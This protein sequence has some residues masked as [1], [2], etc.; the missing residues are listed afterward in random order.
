MPLTAGLYYFLYEHAPPNSVPILLIHGA[1]GMHLSWPSQLRRLPAQTVY[2]LDLPGHG[3]SGGISSQ[4]I[5]DYAE[6]ILTWLD[7]LQLRQ[8]ILCGHSMGGAIA[9]SIALRNPERVPALVL[10]GT[11]ASLRVNRQLLELASRPETVHRAVDLLLEWSFDPSA[12]PSVVQQTRQRLYETP[13][14]L[15]YNDL[16]AC[17]GFDVTQQLP[18]LQ[19]PSLVITGVNDRMTPLRA[20]KLLSEMIPN[21]RFESIPDAGHM[22]ILE[23]PQLVADLILRFL[24]P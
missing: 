6:S 11:A 1:G 5:T 23:Y 12:P 20:G 7:K 19:P 4:A 8:V 14:P 13:V 22:V 15:L 10:I 24:K 17:D 21:A 18:Q 16:L 2:A 9:M 3:K